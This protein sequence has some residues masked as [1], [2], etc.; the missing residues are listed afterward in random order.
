MH[1]HGRPR[2]LCRDGASRFGTVRISLAG[3]IIRAGTRK[4]WLACGSGAQRYSFAIALHFELEPRCQSSLCILR[5]QQRRFALCV[6]RVSMPAPGCVPM[7]HQLMWRFVFHFGDRA[8]RIEDSQAG[9]SVPRGGFGA[10]NSVFRSERA[11]SSRRGG[12]VGGSGRRSRKHS[13]GRRYGKGIDAHRAGSPQ[14]FE[15]TKPACRS[16]KDSAS[17]RGRDS[18]TP[19]PPMSHR[20]GG[21]STA[22][23]FRAQP[24]EL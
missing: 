19:C 24:A 16:G 6:A 7:H 15:N 3:R 20:A 14:T 23:G 4:R 22:R 11:A 13:A 8:R 1:R 5:T 10:L 21:N 18:V 2:C 12:C 17:W 9:G